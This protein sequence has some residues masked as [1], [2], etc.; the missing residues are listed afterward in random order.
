M[1]W[2]SGS[3]AQARQPSCFLKTD[4]QLKWKTWN[5]RRHPSQQ[6]NKKLM[7]NSHTE[8]FRDPL[9]IGFQCA[10]VCPYRFICPCFECILFVSRVITIC[11]CSHWTLLFFLPACFSSFIPLS[12]FCT[13]LFALGPLFPSPPCDGVYTEMHRGGKDLEVASQCPLT[14]SLYSSHL[15]VL[16]GFAPPLH[17]AADLVF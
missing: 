7:G 16:M 1:L 2:L 10:W 3:A 5:E 12:V 13:S 8:L 11:A 9:A 14:I 15:T 6:N 17:P 4:W